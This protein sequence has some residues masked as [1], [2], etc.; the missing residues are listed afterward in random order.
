MPTGAYVF[1]LNTKTEKISLMPFDQFMELKA[2]SEQFESP[3]L[4]AYPQM[5]TGGK[6]VDWPEMVSVRNREKAFVAA[7]S[8]DAKVR[9][10]TTFGIPSIIPFMGRQKFFEKDT[11]YSGV[12]FLELF[13]REKY[14]VPLVQL[15]KR[16][17]S[18]K[19]YPGFSDLALWVQ[20]A[21]RPVLI[22]IE[23]SNRR[24]GKRGLFILVEP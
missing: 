21:G 6:M 14:D 19:S 16:F 1:V 24:L 12:V 13:E 9:E 18:F 11:F 7:V 4:D 15:K 2:V 10:K 22:L 23:E 17:K 3:R 8:F 5:N 20:G